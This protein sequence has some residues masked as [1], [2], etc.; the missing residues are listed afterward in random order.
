MASIDETCGAGKIERC[1]VKRNIST[2]VTRDFF[3]KSGLCTFF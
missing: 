2:E 3:S 1:V